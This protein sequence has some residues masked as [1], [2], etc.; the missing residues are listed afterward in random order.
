MLYWKW[1]AIRRKKSRLLS[2]PGFSPPPLLAVIMAM[3]VMVMMVIMTD[4][5]A[6]R[7]DM[8][9]DNS[10]IGSAGHQAQGHQGRDK[11]FHDRSLLLGFQA[12]VCCG[13]E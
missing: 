12:A 7:A 11:S 3:P 1:C 5:N 4:A 6:D 8:H 9:A 10:R 2:L 13:L